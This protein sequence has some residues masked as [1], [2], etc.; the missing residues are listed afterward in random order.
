MNKLWLFRNLTNM[1]VGTLAF[2]LVGYYVNGV[3]SERK[4]EV[5]IVDQSVVLLNRNNEIKRLAGSPI[6]YIGGSNSS[7]TVNKEGGFYVF[8][9]SGPTARLLAELTGECKSFEEFE[10][11]RPYKRIEGVIA[12]LESERKVTEERLNELQK[13]IK[14]V[15]PKSNEY[16]ALQQQTKEVELRLHLQSEDIKEKKQEQLKLRRKYLEQFYIPDKK[17]YDELK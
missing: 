16:I 17:H 10:Q 14:L 6:S 4:F 11:S 2:C 3:Y 1:T 12:S 7:A 15:K 13:D 9:F 5:P 8:N